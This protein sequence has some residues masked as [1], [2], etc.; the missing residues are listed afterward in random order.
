MNIVVLG[1]PRPLGGANQESG[2]SILMWQRAGI[3]VTAIATSPEPPDNPWP[4]R[5][6]DAGCTI[7]LNDEPV[8][9]LKDAI[10]VAF[11]CEAAVKHWPSLRSR[12][13]KFVYSPCMCRHMPYERTVFPTDPPSAVHFQSAYQKSGMTSQ[14]SRWGVERQPIIPGAFEFDA[15]Q[16]K[17][18]I[19]NGS[20][21]VGKL[22]RPSRTKWPADLWVVLSKAREAARTDLKAL[23]MAWNEEIECRLGRPPSWASCH[24]PVSMTPSTFLHQCHAL[25]CAGSEVEN[26]PRVGLEAMA[27]G[28][29]IIADNAGG[30]VDMI[31]HGETGYLVNSSLEAVDTLITLATNEVKRASII[32]NSYDRLGVLADSLS[33]HS[34]WLN[35]FNSL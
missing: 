2:D 34:S 6:S 1:M 17:P 23:C 11:C 30:W 7:Y 19:R 10:C 21:V 29:P 16:H 27:A 8:K 26:W 3:N 18:A 32:Q 35:L 31:E 13:C 12:G 15:I 33:I 5:L 28:V 25:Y 4:K 22:A 14:F 20:F 24:P 9:E